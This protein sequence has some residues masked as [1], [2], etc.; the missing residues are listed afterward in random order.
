MMN[1]AEQNWPADEV[2]EIEPEDSQQY[3]GHLVDALLELVDKNNR[4]SVPEVK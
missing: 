1:R 3:D 2:H 4:D